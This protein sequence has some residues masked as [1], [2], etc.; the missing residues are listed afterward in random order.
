[1]RRRP[2][3]NRRPSICSKEAIDSPVHQSAQESNRRLRLQTRS[4]CV[5]TQLGGRDGTEPKE[6]AEVSRTHVS[7]APNSRRSVYFG[8]V[9]WSNIEIEYAVFRIVPYY[10]RTQATAPIASIPH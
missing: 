5:S 4:T 6:Q 8:R 9:G 2:S 7:R 1:M 3:S 10:P